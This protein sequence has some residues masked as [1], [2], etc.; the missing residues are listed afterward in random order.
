MSNKNSNWHNRAHTNAFKTVCTKIDTC[1]C[2]GFQNSPRCWL[3]I[4]RELTFA[5]WG[6]SNYNLQDCSCHCNFFHTYIFGGSGFKRMIEL[7][8]TVLL[9]NINF[10]HFSLATFTFFIGYSLFY[11]I[12]IKSI[13]IKS[14]KI[15]RLFY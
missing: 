11:R 7:Q 3:C 5:G 6:Y 15:N 14:T 13:N 10:Y 2:L 1:S 8:K 12:Y 9:S 4:N